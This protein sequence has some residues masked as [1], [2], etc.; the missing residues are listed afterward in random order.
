MANPLILRE[1]Q[2]VLDEIGRVYLEHGRRP[3]WAYLEEFLARQALD[4]GVAVA[5][6]A[7]FVRPRWKLPHRTVSK[8]R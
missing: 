4:A 8:T 7:I 6:D 2:V 5:G 3:A 1:Q